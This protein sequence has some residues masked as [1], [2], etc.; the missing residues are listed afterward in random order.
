MG[1]PCT[2]QAERRDGVVV[3]WLAGELDLP[4]VRLIW[5]DLRQT[6]RRAE[7]GVVLE[8]SGLRFLSSSGLGLLVQLAQDC[9]ARQVPLRLVAPRR[10]TL[11]PLQVTGLDQHV[12]I[13][14]G[15]V[16][17]VVAE[18]TTKRAQP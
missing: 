2:V 11:R 1:Q 4:A 13:A 6:C 16:E 14:T 17:Q 9:A 12:R 8:L 3:A 18:L 10:E 15:D 7:R 5:P